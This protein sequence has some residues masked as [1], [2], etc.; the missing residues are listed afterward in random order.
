ME[1]WPLIFLLAPIAGAIIAMVGYT[2]TQDQGAADTSEA[3]DS[4]IW[5]FLSYT[6]FDDNSQD[7]SLHD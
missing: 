7:H 4:S 6:G 3:G 5:G 1:A 2:A